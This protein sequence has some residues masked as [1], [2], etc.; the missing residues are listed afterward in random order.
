MTAVTRAF[1]RWQKN[2]LWWWW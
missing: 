2:R 1:N